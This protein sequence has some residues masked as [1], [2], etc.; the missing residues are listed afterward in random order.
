MVPLVWIVFL[1]IVSSARSGGAIFD[2]T[3]CATPCS[4][5]FS[6]YALEMLMV[7]L[8]H[9]QQSVLQ[10]QIELAKQREEQAHMTVGLDQMQQSFLELQTELAKHR[11]EAAP[12][13]V[14]SKA[15]MTVGL[16]Q[17]QQSFLGLQ[18]EWAKHREEAA[19]SQ[20]NSDKSLVDIKRAVQNNFDSMRRLEDDVGRNFT[21]LRE[22][23]WQI[24]TQILTRVTPKT[25]PL[26]YVPYRSCSDIR[27]AQSGPYIIQA[28]DES[29]PLMVYCQEDVKGGDSWLVIQH[30]FDGSLNFY[31]NWKEY[32]D[33]FGNIAKEFWIGLE[34][35][36]QLTSGRPH[37]LMVELRDFKGNY[38]FAL[39]EAFKIGSEAEQ[40]N[41][42]TLGAY[43]GTAGDSL[44]YH[45]NMKFSTYDRD[46]DM[47]TGVNCAELFEGAWWY[48]VRSNSNLNGPYRN[49]A[50]GRS[51]HWYDFSN[52]REG[53]SF[54]RMMIRP[55]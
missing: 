25:N 48:N 7:K 24:L 47:W 11:E 26:S 3:D 53:L 30:R 33:G 45:K 15:H 42:K 6:G 21:L 51:M 2:E 40:Y 46:N 20:N 22:Q 9:M 10:L 41:L 5:S 12:S 37:E 1:C 50:D 16:D 17:M 19:Q 4:A 14:D 28:N 44:S 36:H 23:T 38:K 55:K 52:S 31:R 32:R 27:N 29:N 18:S 35:I 39:F 49:T 43:N 13:Q 54:S 34:R 8:D